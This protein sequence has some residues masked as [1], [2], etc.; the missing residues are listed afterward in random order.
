M[1]IQKTY[2]FRVLDD[3]PQGVLSFLWIIRYDLL[4]LGICLCLHLIDLLN[5]IKIV[6][7]VFYCSFMNV[8]RIIN[9][10]SVNLVFRFLS[11]LCKLG[12]QVGISRQ[13]PEIFLFTFGITADKVR[14][15][16]ARFLL[17]ACNANDGGRV[18]TRFKNMKPN[19]IR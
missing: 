13:T 8:R 12:Y 6:R 3:V 16:V 7:S 4:E 1:I 5:L 15:I 10:K 18:F 2:Y 19:R 14:K 9:E 17:Q 11:P